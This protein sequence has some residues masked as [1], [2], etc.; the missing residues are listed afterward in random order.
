M[1]KSSKRKAQ[2]ALKEAPSKS[3]RTKR[4]KTNP[5]DEINMLNNDGL[6]KDIFARLGIGKERF[7][8]LIV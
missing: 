3:R 7:N 2:T 8:L 5:I 4:L 6:T 1:G